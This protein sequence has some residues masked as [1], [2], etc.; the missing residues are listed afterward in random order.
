VTGITNSAEQ[1]EA[2]SFYAALHRDFHGTVTTYA[3]HFL[4]SASTSPADRQRILEDMTGAN[5]VIAV[6]CIETMDRYPLGRKLAMVKKP[7]YLINSSATPT[8]TAALGATG[9]RYQVFDVGRTGHY[10]MI[11]RPAVFDSLL[12]QAIDGIA[13]QQ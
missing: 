11:E 13:R 2:D 4:F 7:L 8:D 12:Q 5:P 3:N 6:A 1:A 9:V 10:P